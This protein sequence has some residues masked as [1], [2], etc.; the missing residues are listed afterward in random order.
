MASLD[1]ES[2]DISYSNMIQMCVCARVCVCV[3]R[4]RGLGT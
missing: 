2:L 4:S 3:Q 1:S